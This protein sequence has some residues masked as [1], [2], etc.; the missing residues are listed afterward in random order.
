MSALA[1]LLPMVA[2]AVAARSAGP[3]PGR[4]LVAAVLG[5]LLGATAVRPLIRRLGRHIR[6]GLAER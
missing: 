2:A 3:Q 5:L 6:A 4:Q 1:F